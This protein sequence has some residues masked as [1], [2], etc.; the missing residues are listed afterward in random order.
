[1]ADKT[2]GSLPQASVLADDS[3]F[4]CEDS[5]VA[6]QVS[7]KQLKEFFVE[8][9]GVLY[10]SEQTLADAQKSTARQN[11]GAVSSN[12]VTAAINTALGDYS[13]ALS[14]IDVIIGGGS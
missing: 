5:G 1:M 11:I 10:N 7:G 8:F 2:I 12:D 3:K 6:K 4:V 14:D 9:G 13:T